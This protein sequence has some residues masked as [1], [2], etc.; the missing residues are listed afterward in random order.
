VENWGCQRREAGWHSFFFINRFDLI[1]NYSRIQAVSHCQPTLQKSRISLGGL[2]VWVLLLSGW[3]VLAGCQANPP[4][5]APAAIRSI[6]VV[7][8]NNYPPYTYLDSSGNLQGILIDEW[9]LWE[10][11]T[12]IRVSITGLDWA[13][14]LTRM[15]NGEFDV[16][17]TLFYNETRAQ[18]YD[19]SQPY[20]KLDVPIFFYNHISGITDIESLKGFPVAVKRGDNAVDLL[21][22]H[23]ITQILEYNSYE[24]IISAA[25][26][27]KVIVF[28]VDQPPALYY[29]YKYGIQAEFNQ[30]APLYSGEFHRA[31]LKGNQ[32]LLS[33][34]ENGFRQLSKEELAQIER[35]WMGQSQAN[36][37]LL[38][39]AGIAGAMIAILVLLLSAWNYSLRRTVAR[40]TRDL[41][42]A[43]QELSGSEQKYRQLVANIPGAVYR[44]AYDPDWTLL[45]LSDAA[46]DL[47][48][49]SPADLAAQ[50]ASGLVELIDP[51]DRAETIQS[52]ENAMA[53]GGHFSVDF[54]LVRADQT[55]RWVSNRGQAVVNSDGDVEWVDGVI[56]DISERKQAEA[57]LFGSEQRLRAT[58]DSLDDLVFVFD[59]DRRIQNLYYSIDPAHLYQDPKN[60]LGR[61]LEDLNFPA[62]IIDQFNEAFSRVQST[63]SSQSFVYTLPAPEGVHWYNAR[64]SLQQDP[65]GQFT[66]VTAVVSNITDQKQAEQALHTRELEARTLSHLLSALTRVSMHL[67]ITTHTDDLMRSAVELGV[68][69]LGF[70]RIGIWR[71]DPQ[72]VNIMR[73]TFGID[74]QG[75]LRDERNK[76]YVDDPGLR[77]AEMANGI[78]GVS[79]YPDS[80]LLNDH[81]EMVGRGERATAPLWDGQKVNG[82]IAVDNYI[83]RQPIDAQH[84]EILM[85]FAQS[86]GH[87]YTLKET[88]A[89]LRQLNESLEARVAQRTAQLEASNREMQAFSYSISHDLRTPLR[90]LISFSQ[91]LESEVGDNLD[92]TAKDYLN[93]IQAASRRMSDRI[94]ALLKLTRISR[95]EIRS[96][97]I[98]LDVIAQEIA[99]SLQST[100]PERVVNWTIKPGLSCRADPDLIRDALENLLG[101]AW[102]F[103]SHHSQARIE[104]GQAEFR[105]KQAFYVRDDGAGFDMAYAQQLFHAFRRLHTVTEFDGTGIGL[106]IVQRIIQR[107]GGEIWADSNPEH[108]ATF[109]FTLPLE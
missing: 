35:K 6:R 71:I 88:E 32:E 46:Q 85:L 75:N 19:F 9:K 11:K 89:A 90:S 91:I 24:E 34:V 77:A 40:R 15:A 8:D 21:Q 92:E 102:K 68:K 82:Y 42:T 16:I 65:A 93:R 109:T 31:V 1:R 98:Q 76:F 69:E 80:K 60:A 106:A 73:G 25:K 2:F 41:H 55:T 26:A 27:Q 56:F 23:G 79:Y 51:A 66:G 97:W 87:L 53:A 44:C 78:V 39:D 30:T 33:T 101:N 50:P 38:R 62:Q 59:P 43:I 5:Q 61:R 47:L 94:D 28:V 29:L 99:E 86:V 14:A 72:D 13:Q 84:R 81:R 70:D 45:Y 10:Q 52:V 74:E 7:M 49:L 3:G 48:G 100:Q 64:L 83:H 63:G 103:T 67:S 96:E 20:A 54:R 105:G 12:G 95:S 17:D 104:V 107:H 108:G 57:A 36:P 58:I 22:R 37:Y 18:L 4:A